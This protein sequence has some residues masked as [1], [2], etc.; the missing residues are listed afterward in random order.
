MGAK[1]AGSASANGDED[2]EEKEGGVEECAE[3]ADECPQYLVLFWCSRSVL[4]PHNL[5][6]DSVRV[7]A[8]L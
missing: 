7:R 6:N 5:V 3:D 2:A 4:L 8:D 1:H